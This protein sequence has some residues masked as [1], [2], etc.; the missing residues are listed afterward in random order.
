MPRQFPLGFVAR[1]Q[2]FA[3]VRLVRALT[4]GLGFS[5]NENSLRHR[6]DGTEGRIGREAVKFPTKEQIGPCDIGSNHA[7]TEL[8]PQLRGLNSCV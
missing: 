2:L 5:P 6:R 8:S 1:H 4:I 3:Y 7:I